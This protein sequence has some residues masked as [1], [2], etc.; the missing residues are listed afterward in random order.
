M[1]RNKGGDCVNYRKAHVVAG[2]NFLLFLWYAS[3]NEGEGR[4]WRGK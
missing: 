2:F 4:G 1:G 3:K